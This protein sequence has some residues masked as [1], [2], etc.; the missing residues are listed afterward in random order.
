MMQ[1]MEPGEVAEITALTTIPEAQPFTF[2]GEMMAWSIKKVNSKPNAPMATLRLFRNVS[3]NVPNKRR[4]VLVFEKFTP[5]GRT[6]IASY[7]CFPSLAKL[8][9]KSPDDKLHRRIVQLISS[10]ISEERSLKEG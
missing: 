7:R 3:D 5:D 9:E 1:R 8:E 10:K 4:F 6:I 2:M